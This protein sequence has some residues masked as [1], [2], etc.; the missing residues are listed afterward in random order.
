MGPSKYEQ[1]DDNKHRDLKLSLNRSYP[2]ASKQYLLP[3]TAPEIVAMACCYPIMLTKDSNTG[4]FRIAAVTNFLPGNNLLYQS[5]YWDAGTIPLSISTAPFAMQYQEDNEKK[6]FIDTN[7]DYVSDQGEK[8][9]DDGKLNAR[10]QG[11]VEKLEQYV[12]FSQQ[13]QSFIQTLIELNF[14]NELLIELNFSDGTTKKLQGSYGI[15]FDAL[16]LLDRDQLLDLQKKGYLS[17]IIAM[18]NSLNQ[19]S[20]LRHLFNLN[21]EKKIEN[22]KIQL[23]K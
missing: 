10:F 17:Q 6:I 2:H 11:H 23:I 16:E 22:I 15:E 12:L 19:F 4:Q 8:L 5:S 3:L 7:S 20:H 1:L 9:L 13:T 21:S 18:Q 14:I